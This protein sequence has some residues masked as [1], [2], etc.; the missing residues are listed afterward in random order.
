MTIDQIIENALIEDLGDGDHTSRATIPL[1]TKGKAGLYA[2]QTGILA[3]MNI[4]EKVFLKVDASTNFT[5][6]HPSD[7]CAATLAL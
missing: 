1:K 3:G 5:A 2:K 6:T 4:A 7:R